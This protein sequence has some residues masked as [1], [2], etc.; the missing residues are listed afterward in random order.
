MKSIG[1]WPLFTGALPL[2]AIPAALIGRLLGEKWWILSVFGWA[3]SGSSASCAFFVYLLF[4]RK[5]GERFTSASLWF[6]GYALA[7]MAVVAFLRF[8]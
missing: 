8:A 5:K 1:W 2:I 4:S 6:V 7:W 3:L